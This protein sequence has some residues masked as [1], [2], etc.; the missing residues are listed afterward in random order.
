MPSLIILW[1]RFGPYHHAR[2]QGARE[3]LLP[4]GWTVTG[5][6]V[7][8][9]DQYAWSSRTDQ[10]AE[11]LTLFPNTL[12]E[13]LHRVPLRTRLTS[14]LNDLNPRAIAING[15]AAP[16]ALVA[17]GWCQK[18]HRAAFLMSETHQPSRVWWKEAVKR[19]RVKRFD[20]AL[21]GGRWHG[22]YLASL[23]F[24]RDKIF[25]G[26]D[27]VDNRHFAQFR[28]AS[29]ASLEELRKQKGLPHTYFF[30]NTRFVPRKNIDGLLRA[31]A[32]Y[33]GRN[34]PGKQ[35]WDL[36]ISG[37]GDMEDHWR[38]LAK[39]LGIA[40]SV[41][42][43]GF[44]QYDALPIYYALA[45]AFVHP[46]HQE[47]WGLV[48]NEAAAA[49]LPLIV[50]DTA[51]A[52]CELV[53]EGENGFLVRPACPHSIAAALCRI[54]QLSPAE[55]RQFGEASRRLASNFGP[56]RFGEGLGACLQTIDKGPIDVTGN[57]SVVLHR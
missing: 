24:P 9:R 38:D 39:Q 7:A 50:A 43:P 19:W 17:L 2:L 21:V 10:R 28:H 49:G 13:T 53:H 25:A 46:A 11:F 57:N 23:G 52:S 8:D 55:R 12:Y 45:G 34:E 16:E 22:D 36:V 37:S 18:R 40:E 3:A 31:Y 27:S 5:V 30:A 29:S 41:H 14:T 42:W 6:E 26:Y 20:A 33:R 47:A 48:V 4:R 56:A 35:P 54:T 15:W 44:L 51:G 32:S 1:Q